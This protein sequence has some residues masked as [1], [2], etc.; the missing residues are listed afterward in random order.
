MRSVDFNSTNNDK[1]KN[2]ESDVII[3]INFEMWN[4]TWFYHFF[5]E[6]KS[7]RIQ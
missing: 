2:N 5:G 1:L 4:E 6:P 7:V 3:V